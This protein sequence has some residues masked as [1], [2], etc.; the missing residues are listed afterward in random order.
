MEFSFVTLPIS[1]V[2]LLVG[3]H[4]GV[5]YWMER[6]LFI[7]LTTKVT[8]HQWY[9]SYE[10]QEANLCSNIEE[11]VSLNSYMTQTGESKVGGFNLLEVSEILCAP[12][13]NVVRFIVTGYDVIHC[14]AIPPLGIKV[15]AIPGKHNAISLNLENYGYFYGQCS[16]ICGSQHAFMPIVL[17]VA[18]SLHFLSWISLTQG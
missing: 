3:S 4:F 1:L 14:F 18:S 16:E 11:P 8:G 15:D 10:I 6:P 5:S 17:H 9:W 2:T 13:D 12:V 7:N